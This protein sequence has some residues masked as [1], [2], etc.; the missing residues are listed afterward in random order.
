MRNKDW[1]IESKHNLFDL[2]LKEMICYRHLL[3]QLII[4]DVLALYKQTILGPIWF[5][6]QPLLTTVVF[7]FVFG[8]LAGVST[9]GLPQHLFYLAGIIN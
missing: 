5:F 6:I 7:T 4:R 2:R 8:K 1:I 9:D 3:I